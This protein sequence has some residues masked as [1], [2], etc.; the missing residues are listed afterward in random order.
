MQMGKF[1]PGYYYMNEWNFNSVIDIDGN[2]FA[3]FSNIHHGGF[4]A[5]KKQLE[6]I[7]NIKCDVYENWISSED[8]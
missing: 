1:Y 3:E 4:L 5:T 8:E 6:K 2:K 7:I